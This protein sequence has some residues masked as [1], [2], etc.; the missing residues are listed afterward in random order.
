MPA[1]LQSFDDSA[2]PARV[3]PHLKL[4]RSAMAEAGVDAFLIPRADAHRGEMVPPGD[5]RLAWATGFTGSAGIGVVSAGAAAL[6]VD[7]RYHLQAPLET[8]TGLVDV[9]PQPPGKPSAW[10]KE[11]LTAP[12]RVG[13]DPWLH[14]PAER[15]RLKKSLER[16]GLDLVAIDNPLDA[17][18]ADRPPPPATPV[19]VLDLAR[20][21]QSATEKLEAAADQIRQAPADALVLSVPESICWLFNI[22]GRDVAHTPVTLAYAI[23]HADGRAELFLNPLKLTDEL[24]AALGDAPALRPSEELADALQT[25]GEQGAGV[26]IDPESSPAAIADLLTGAGATLVERRDPVLLPKSKKNPVEIAGMREAHRVDAVAVARFLAWVDA[27][28][29]K[30][31]LTEIDLVE[32]LEATRRR[33][34]SF[35]DTS[36]DTIAGAGPNGAIVHY[37]VT[38]SSNRRIAPGE[39]V[40]VD[41]GGHYRQGT[42]DIT[43][44]VATG[45]ATDTQRD[46]FTRVLKGMICLTTIRFPAGTSGQELDPLARQYLWRAGMDYGHGTGHGVGAYLSVHEGPCSISRRPSAVLEPGMVLSNEPGFYA[47]G[48][49]GIRTENLMVVAED[50]E[51][52]DGKP[53][54]SF[55]T[56][57]LAPIDVR[58]IDRGQLTDAE[59]DWLNAYHARVFEEIGPLLEPPDRAWLEAATKP[60]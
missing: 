39:L 50:G 37:R 21:G 58:L 12:A 34:N 46:A 3:A 43:R 33:A 42:T 49:F 44:T 56:L 10:L 26:W 19:E 29:P 17:V 2:D 51:G 6:F 14:T 53:W 55:E 24:R 18:W 13:Y 22:R 20:A 38:R 31:E 15:R 35:L 9:I 8:D 59:L 11:H 27:E 52:T 16:T 4:L 60:L 45:P 32:Q 48:E 28:A 47:E 7:G 5:E 57:T 23:V 1:A 40:L 41:S 36:F 30:G 54:L 25:L